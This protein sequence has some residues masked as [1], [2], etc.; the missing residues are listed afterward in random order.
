MVSA[1]RVA[2]RNFLAIIS[3]NV[4][5]CFHIFIDHIAAFELSFTRTTYRHNKK[6]NHQDGGS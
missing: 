1:Y 3:I 2:S 4:I 5:L 6:K